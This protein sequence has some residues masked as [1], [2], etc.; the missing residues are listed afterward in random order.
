MIFYAHSGQDWEGKSDWQSLSDHL[1]Q[2][3]ELAGKSG[4][5]IGLG[6]VARLAGLLHDLGK[7]NADFQNKLAGEA[8][9][10]NHSTAG[11]KIVEEIVE[12]ADMV[13]KLCA[14]I[15]QYCI[16]G[17]HAGLP[18]YSASAA[19]KGRSLEQRLKYF[20]EEEG[21]DLSPQ[22]QKEIYPSLEGLALSQPLMAAL[23]TSTYKG[24]DLSFII[25]MVFSCLIDADRRNT[26]E[27]CEQKE[28]ESYRSLAEILPDLLQSYQSFMASMRQAAEKTDSSANQKLNTL[29]NKI[30]DTVLAKASQA[31]SFYT[32]NVPTGGGKTLTSLGFALRHAKTHNLERIIYALPFT[33]IIDQTAE[34]FKKLLGEDNVLEHHSNF[35]LPEKGEGGEKQQQSR[36]RLKAAMEDW[37]APLIVTSNVQLFESLYAAK[38]STARKLK[39]IANSLIILDEAQTIPLPLLAPCVRALDSLV[40]LFGCTVVL[41]TATQP[42][43]DEAHMVAE[44]KIAALP[45]AGKELAPDP[46]ELAE[47]LHR[48]TIEFAG[49]MSNDALIAA[50]AESEQGLIIVNSRKHAYELYEQAKKAGVTG[51]IHLTTRQAAIHRKQ[52]I[53]EIRSKLKQGRPCRV[54]ATSLV[55]AGVDFDFPRVWRAEAGLDSVLQAAGRC[56]REG[57]RPREQSIVT[58]F[59]AE[60]SYSVPYDIKKQ[61][62]IL[63][64]LIAEYGDKLY[65]PKAI[66]TY[67]SKTYWS[68]ELDAKNIIREDLKVLNLHY[69][70]RQIGEKFQMIESGMEPV[71]I[72]GIDDKVTEIIGQM[73]VEAISSG[74]LARQLQPY[75]VQIPPKARAKLIVNSHVKFMARELRGDQF[76]VLTATGLYNKER[77]LLWEEADYLTLE[78]SIY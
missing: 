10:V 28:R 39:N 19:E 54:I 71:I 76:A 52:I 44:R 23:R 5:K 8:V 31:K 72:A 21:K 69:P 59:E 37:N 34:I 58:V 1:R 32:L 53:A 42:A 45:L 35:A 14:K 43:L 22:W 33:S 56:N 46:Q 50:L 73:S 26:Q 12:N 27:F 55:E 18:D 41:C 57:L 3:A 15:I 16:L 67:F 13:Q 6:A 20:Y 9:A 65:S 49:E 38:A 2:T 4:D 36:E 11:A 75:I 60:K 66:E 7:Y 30:L 64:T 40:R 24:V 25:R 68:D 61:A 29:R 51:L 17:H 63:E 74:A 48:A 47:E 62:K 77:G 78:Q 70:L